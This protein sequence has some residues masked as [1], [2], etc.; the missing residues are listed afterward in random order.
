M[1]K[2]IGYGLILG[3]LVASLRWMEYSFMIRDH[4]VEL[5]GGLVAVLFT[6]M[7]IWLGLKITRPKKVVVIKEVPVIQPVNFTLDEKKLKSLG[8]SKR[9]YE[10]L[11]LI[12]EGFSN[13]EIADKLFLSQNTIKTHS[14]NLF[15]KLEA[16][17]R[18][19][20]VQKAK[21]LGLIP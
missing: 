12:A 9:E 2:I 1:K 8:I 11:Q 15:S 20:A 7:G 6:A 18:T 19:Q 4:A 10:I 5:Y 13:Q 14:S 3:V 21:N 17:R 16:S